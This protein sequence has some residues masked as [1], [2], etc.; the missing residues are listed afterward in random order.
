MIQISHM[1]KLNL[2]TS[3]SVDI[4]FIYCEASF[5]VDS[6]SKQNV[7]MKKVKEWR[8]GEEKTLRGGSSS[9]EQLTRDKSHSIPTITFNPRD[10][11][12]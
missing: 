1:I 2:L 4:C 11:W 10:C 8:K 6:V 5:C 12:D 7:K 9:K 3:L